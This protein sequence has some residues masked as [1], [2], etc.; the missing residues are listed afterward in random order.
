LFRALQG[1]RRDTSGL[2]T[3]ELFR[4][5]LKFRVSSGM[6]YAISSV[7]GVALQEWL[8]EDIDLFSKME[9]FARQV[10][11]SLFCLLTNGVTGGSTS[12]V[13]RDL[14]CLGSNGELLDR[15][16][17]SLTD[18]GYVQQ[19]LNLHELQHTSPNLLVRLNDSSSRKRISPLIHHAVKQIHSRQE[20]VEISSSPD[21]VY[22]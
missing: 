16:S 12:Q 1:L 15:I 7:S 20:R 21:S 19:N 9:R 10:N 5:D 6:R 14:V 13:M 18:S 8:A 22:I 3:A 4:K 11:V 17:E 2:S